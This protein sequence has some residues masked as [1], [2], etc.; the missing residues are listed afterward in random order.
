MTGY[1]DRQPVGTAPYKPYFFAGTVALLGYGYYLVYWKP[2]QDCAPDE[3]CARPLPNR[4]VKVV[5]W[6]ATVL[7]VVAAS[8]DYIAPLLLGA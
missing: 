2:K 7:V 1:V 3:A 4:F 6:G 5:L 8:S